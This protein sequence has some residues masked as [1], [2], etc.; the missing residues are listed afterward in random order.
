EYLP[1]VVSAEEVPR[2]KPAPDVFL[3]AARRLG[4]PPHACAVVEDSQHGVEA[5]SRAFM[6]CIAVPYLVDEP[7]PDAFLM[8]DLLFE[9]GMSAFDASRALDWVE[10][11]LGDEALSGPHPLE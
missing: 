3:E 5:A 1:I 4:V 7:L 10:E 8:A 9:R 6:R 11:R 2:G